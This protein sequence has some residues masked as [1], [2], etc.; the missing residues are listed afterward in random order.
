MTK[1]H[2]A[3]VVLFG[4]TRALSGPLF[5]SSPIKLVV[6]AAVVVV[7]LVEIPSLVL[8]HSES[9]N[10]EPDWRSR[11]LCCPSLV[12]SWLGFDP[13]IRTRSDEDDNNKRNT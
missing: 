8:W 12:Y 9:K 10:L 7:V 2:L 5:L 1:T 13:T 11:E 4:A 6:L 3:L